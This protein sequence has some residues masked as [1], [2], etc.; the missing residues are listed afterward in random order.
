MISV[1]IKELKLYQQIF[2][3]ITPIITNMGFINVIVV[4]VRLRWFRQRFK[5]FGTYDF[6][7]SK[8]VARFNTYD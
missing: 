7:T 4:A 5:G 6:Q 8:S 2:I 1:D 3:Y